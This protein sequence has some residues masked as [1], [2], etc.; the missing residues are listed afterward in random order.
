M[1]SPSH[2]NLAS[3]GVGKVASTE[4]MSVHPFSYAGFMETNSF[5]RVLQGQEICPVKSL[6][7]KVDLS[8]GS[9]GKP[10]ESCTTFNL[11]QATKPNFQ[12]A[13]FPYGDIH[14]AGQASM[15]GSKPTTF[16]RENVSF[17]TPFAQ[18]G[19]I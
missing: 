13:Y 15:F 7:G 8:C 2:P 1:S 3:T 12:S 10:N 9:W 14:R 11:H 6:T 19:I 16:Q 18:A 4:L 5:P 17:N